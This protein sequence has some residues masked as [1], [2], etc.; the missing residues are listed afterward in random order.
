[1]DYR[2]LGRTGVSVSQMCLG[3]MMFG[4]FGNPDHDDAV[5]IIHQALDAGVNFIDTADGYSAGESEQII[6][7]ALAGGRRENVVLAVK[8]GPPFDEDPNHRG[9]SR[10]WITEGVEGSLRRLQTDW[11]DLYQVGVPDPNTDIDE[12]LSALST[13]CTPAR[14]DPSARQSSPRLRSSRL[15]GPPI[16]AATDGF[17]PSSPPTPC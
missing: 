10:R 6:G 15:N 8:F 4:A 3:A 7:K 16:A 17:A 1:M 2:P 12:T 9:A 11:I 14:S 13:S 5:R